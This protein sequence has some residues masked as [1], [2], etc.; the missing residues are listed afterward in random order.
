MRE[1][2]CDRSEAGYWPK[3]LGI[4]F[5][6]EKL[7][8]WTWEVFSKCFS[9]SSRS[10]DSLWHRLVAMC[11]VYTFLSVIFLVL[12]LL[13][14]SIHQCWVQ[15]WSRSRLFL[16]LVLILVLSYVQSLW[17]F[18]FCVW[19][20]SRHLWSRTQHCHPPVHQTPNTKPP[21]YHYK[22]NTALC[23]VKSWVTIQRQSKPELRRFTPK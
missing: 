13:S 11:I 1:W 18:Q 5:N 20:L 3:L 9:F 14:I 22:M 7:P 4:N 15:D 19:S 6:F 2:F 12:W 10:F 17:D 21:C 23:Y 16:V 8:V